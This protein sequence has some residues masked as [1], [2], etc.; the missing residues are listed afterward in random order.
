VRVS[1][2]TNNFEKELLNI[3]NYSMGF[4]EG[5][6]KGKKV[7]LDNLGRGVIFALGQYIDVEARANRDALHHVY[8]WYQTGSPQARLFDINYTV[9]NLGLSINSTFRQSRTLQ[10]D[11][12]T[13]FY[14]KAKIMEDGIPVVIRPKKNSVLRFYEGGETVFTSK[15]VTVRNPGGNQVEG[16]FERV[17][18]E[19]MAR[20]F[21][22]AFLRASG[23]SDYISNPIIYKKNIAAGAKQGRS[24]GVSTGYKWITNAKIEV[25]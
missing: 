7:F 20:Y 21:T 18:D 16:S 5:A 15:P 13:P 25:E 4:L 24:K 1:I 17:F 8:E 10:Q 2:K 12:T 19:F 9:S 14:N 22:Q 3:A 23:I 6:Q 11:A